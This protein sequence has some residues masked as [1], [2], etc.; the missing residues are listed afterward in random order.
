MLPSLTYLRLFART[1]NG[2]YSLFDGFRWGH[3]IKGGKAHSE[4]FEWMGMV[5][6]MGMATN[7]W[8]WIGMAANG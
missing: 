8:E 4:P 5:G 6:N 7:G 2:D 1:S 3:L